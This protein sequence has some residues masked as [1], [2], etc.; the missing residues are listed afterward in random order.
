MN[1]E[2]AA[3]ATGPDVG[4]AVAVCVPALN[5]ADAAAVAAPI[6]GPALAVNVPAAA[7]YVPSNCA[8]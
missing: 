5:V 7:V 2:E 8:P 1:V 4:S 6:V 3:A